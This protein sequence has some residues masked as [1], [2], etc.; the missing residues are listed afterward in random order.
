MEGTTDGEVLAGGLGRGVQFRLRGGMSGGW[1]RPS[2]EWGRDWG[3]LGHLGDSALRTEPGEK[4]WR[5]LEKEEIKLA[6]DRGHSA[7]LVACVRMD[8]AGEAAGRPRSCD[9]GV[10][11][12]ILPRVR[13]RLALQGGTGDF[14]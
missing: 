1:W 6:C 14:P 5:V 8:R 12:Q 11:G 9:A 10:S 3:G 4:H 2:K 7:P 13:D